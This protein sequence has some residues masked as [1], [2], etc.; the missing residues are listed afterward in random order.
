M[1]PVMAG[2]DFQLNFPIFLLY[3]AKF[4]ETIIMNSF[5]IGE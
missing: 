4:G 3:L 2:I 1:N 5:P